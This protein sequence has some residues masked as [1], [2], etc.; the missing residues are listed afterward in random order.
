MADQIV[1]IQPDIIRVDVGLPDIIR[2]DVGLPGPP[3]PPG[4]P[5]TG[6]PGDFFQTALR[7]AELDTDEKR[8]AA[9]TNLGLATI[10]GGEFFTATP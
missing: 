1:I 7:L 8:I 10:D 6:E 9:R 5:A 3:G 4:S 2:V